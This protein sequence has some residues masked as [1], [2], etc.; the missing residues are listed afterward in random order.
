MSEDDVLFHDEAEDGDLLD[1]RAPAKAPWKVMIVDDEPA[2]HAITRLALR[3]LTFEGRGLEWISAESAREARR[4]LAEHPDTALILLDVV[5]ETDEA[6][7][8]F[9]RH[10]RQEAGNQLV[11]IV[12]RTGQ[13]GQAPEQ[14]VIQE[15]D[16]NDYK[17][18]T[19]LTAQRLFTTVIAA[20]RSHRD[21]LRLDSQRRAIEKIAATT[22]IVGD[23]DAG[24]SFLGKSL[25]ILADLVAPRT[26]AAVRASFLRVEANG[27]LS[28]LSGEPL[29]PGA[30]AGAAVTSARSQFNGNRG[31]IFRGRS[32]DGGILMLI[33]A[34]ER[35]DEDQKSLLEVFAAKL[36]AEQQSHE[37][38]GQLRQAQ[39]ATILSLARLAEYKDTD[40]GDHLRRVELGS[41]GLSAVLHERG[42]FPEIID[43]LFLDQIGQASILHD[44]GKVGVPEKILL[45]PGPLDA[46]EWEVM[47]SHAAIGGAI[48]G[49]AA[50]LL[51]G[52]NYLSLAS[53]IALGHHEKFDGTGYP[54]G[55]TGDEIPVSARVVA[56]VDVFDALTSKR[57]YK[58]PWPLDK[59][60]AKL[61][62]LSGTHFD[63]RMVAAFETWLTR[64]AV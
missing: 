18:K 1:R 16:I 6:G 26:P 12:L 30:E 43:Q 22:A 63:P 36:A 2:V 47:R 57:P 53:E 52:R 55:V 61:Q 11:R 28:L 23:S 15:F 48:L 4:Q 13:P 29:D 34:P 45:K 27:A 37:L 60:V 41:R 51:G 9:A 33:E 20:L 10:V 40:T 7:L 32:S 44:V 3:D 49:D 39:E 54:G 46:A 24:A 31:A 8:N 17:T 59:A 64:Q 25:G 14:S 5:M 50:Q 58:E 38:Y 42:L 62:E 21:L 19:E 35:I 56:V